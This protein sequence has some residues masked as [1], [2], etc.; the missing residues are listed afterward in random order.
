MKSAALFAI[1]ALVLSYGCIQRNEQPASTSSDLVK[2]EKPVAG[3]LWSYS[4]KWDRSHDM[5]MRVATYVIPSGLEDLDAGECAVFYFG[6]DQGG[7]VDANIQ[8]WGSQFEGASEAQKT[9]STVGDMQ[10]VYAR[11]QGTYLSPAGP[12]MESQGKKAGYKL[13]SAIVSAPEGNVFFKF[14]GPALVVEQHEKEFYSM[15][16]S[17]EK[18]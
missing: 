5:P 12:Q 11:I 17:I 15:I 9:T 14:T 6:Q 2:E 18:Q 7:D 13:V 1:I 3:I 16:D 4:K 8:R 10:V